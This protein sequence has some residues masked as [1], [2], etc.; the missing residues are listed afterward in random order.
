MTQSSAPSPNTQ[1]HP[2]PGRRT[3]SPAPRHRG[4]RRPGAGAPRGNLNALK[5]SRFSN[6]MIV[7]GMVMAVFPEVGRF[8]D[9]VI[10]DNQGKRRQT[11]KDLLLASRLPNKPPYLT[12]SI[13]LQSIDRLENAL[14]YIRGSLPDA[15]KNDQTIT[16]SNS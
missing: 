12:D 10:N 4:G 7:A 6:D 5:H 14:R 2:E 9:M 16:Q 15:I 11:Y 8:F 13:K 3:P 1:L